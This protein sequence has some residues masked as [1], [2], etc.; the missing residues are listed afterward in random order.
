MPVPT[1]TIREWMGRYV[2][3]RWLR[4]THTAHACKNGR[5]HST[6]ACKYGRTYIREVTAR[7]DARLDK[8]GEGPRGLAAVAALAEAT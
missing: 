5:T 1:C 4:S 2:R 7:H 3:K 6:H 8:P